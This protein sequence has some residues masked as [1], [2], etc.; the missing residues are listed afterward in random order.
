M[1]DRIILPIGEGGARESV[2][3]ARPLA[4]ALGCTLT[5]LHIHQ[6]R[7]APAALEG[8]TQFRYQGVVE[9]W[10]QRDHA[11]EEHEVEWLRGVAEEIAAEEP[12]LAVSSLV[13]HSPLTRRL[14]ADGES[15]LVLAPAGDAHLDG[16]AP[17]TQE[18]LSRG[19]APVLL[20]RP[21]VE[22][23]PIRRLLIALDGSPFSQNILD[24]ALEL[25]RATGARIS[26]LEV[27]TGKGGLRG[28]LHPGERSAETA[29]QFLRE[30]RGRIPEALG[31]VDVRVVEMG[32][33][34]AGIAAE[35]R[36]ENI[37]LVA[38]A[39]HGRGGLRRAL[40]GSVA[41]S[42]VR[43]SRVAVLLYHPLGYAGRRSAPRDAD[44]A[45][46]QI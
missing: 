2:E 32:N 42:V 31:P 35:T 1:Y 37:D 19:G 26:L 41:Q 20:F 38:L 10:D 5:L 33:A 43:S 17:T 29:E 34:A 8:L 27:V 18:I 24:P 21:D 40:L 44:P 4:R 23:L 22:L 25:A 12:D 30:V 28:L 15:V 7:E 39:T 36:R 6:A 3:R 9:T 46:A 16:L 11:A 14:H 45:E 13:I